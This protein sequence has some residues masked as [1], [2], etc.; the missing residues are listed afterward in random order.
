MGFFG[1]FRICPETQIL[2][3]YIFSGRIWPDFWKDNSA[4]I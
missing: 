3:V 1:T 4:I 2:S